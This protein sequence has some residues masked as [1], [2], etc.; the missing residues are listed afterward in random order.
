MLS[1]IVRWAEIYV[2]SKRTWRHMPLWMFAFV[3]WTGRVYSSAWR[4]G[5]RF[6]DVERA[7]SRLAPRPWLAIHGGRDASIGP[8]IARELFRRA[9]DP[10]ELWVV[11]EAKHNRC[12]EADPDAY[13]LRLEA[14]FRRYAPRRL[15][16]SSEA[17][18]TAPTR[19]RRTAAVGVAD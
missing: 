13:R 7:V 12:R 10:K 4:L 6:P 18:D 3:G 19:S 2:G 16:S 11:P 15:P 17:R 8:E 14:F 5:R 9:G 1:Y